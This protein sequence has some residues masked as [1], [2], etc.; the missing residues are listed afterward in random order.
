MS[1]QH[2]CGNCDGETDANKTFAKALLKTCQVGDDELVQ[3]ILSTNGVNVN[4]LDCND[5]TPLSRAVINKPNTVRIFLFRT[6]ALVLL[7]RK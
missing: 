1:E 3:E 6:T 2:L 7:G 4:S 5:S